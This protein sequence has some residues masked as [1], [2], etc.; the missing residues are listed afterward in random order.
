MLCLECGEGREDFESCST[1]SGY[2]SI[3][4]DMS[5]PVGGGS[6]ENKK[7]EEV[8]ERRGVIDMEENA[9]TPPDGGLRVRKMKSYTVHTANTC[10]L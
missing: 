4:T 3:V 10:V 5:T 6:K 2:S 9:F 7:T 8:E 1:T